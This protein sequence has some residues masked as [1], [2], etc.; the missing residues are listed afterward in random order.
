[1]IQIG[2]FNVSITVCDSK[3]LELETRNN[4]SV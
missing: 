4:Y 2:L 3:Q 1:M